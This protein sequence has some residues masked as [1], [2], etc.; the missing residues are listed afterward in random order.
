MDLQWW[1]LEL[2]DC[3]R[4]QGDIIATMRKSDDEGLYESYKRIC[5]RI[6]YLEACTIAGYDVGAW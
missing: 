6:E 2:V 4:K 3:L 5:N 1:E